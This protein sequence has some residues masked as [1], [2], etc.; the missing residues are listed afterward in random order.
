VFIIGQIYP[1]DQARF[2]VPLKLEVPAPTSPAENPLYEI[3][4]SNEPVFSFR[5]IRKSSGSVLFDTSLGG[6]TFAQQFI[7]F[8]TKLPSTNLY[9]IGENEQQSFRHQFHKFQKFAIF[10]RDHAPDVS[11]GIFKY[12][13]PYYMALIFFSLKGNTNLYGV[14]PHYTVIESDGN[15]HAVMIV[16]SNAMGNG[17]SRSHA[18]QGRRRKRREFRIEFTISV[19]S[20]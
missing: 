15:A 17:Q 11:S 6:L 7:Q 20:S 5:V 12:P 16:N 10:S 4:F 8:S 1:K 3:Q 2:E 18:V 14:Q 9:G 19:Q 13:S